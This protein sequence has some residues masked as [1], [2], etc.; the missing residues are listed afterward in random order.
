MYL[1]NKQEVSLVVPI[2]AIRGLRLQNGQW[3]LYVSDPAPMAVSVFRLPLKTLESA[4][5]S[6]HTYTTSVR[7]CSNDG[8]K[9]WK[10]LLNEEK[11]EVELVEAAGLPLMFPKISGASSN[12]NLGMKVLQMER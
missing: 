1:Q 11:I 7:I 9:L 3:L 5:A 10:W 4:L 2:E 6:V 8:E 12:P